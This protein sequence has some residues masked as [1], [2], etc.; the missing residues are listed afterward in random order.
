MTIVTAQ[1]NGLRIAPRKVRLLAALIKGKNLDAALD[2]LGHFTRRGGPHLAKLLESAAANAEANFKL[3]RDGL[4]VKDLRVDE[5]IKLKR[6]RPKGFGRAAPLQK[7]TSR[8]KV[9]LA[10][11]EAKKSETAVTTETK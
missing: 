1:L 2:Q 9:V 4:Y 10:E 5:G 11:R 8:V 7:K 6:F 3:G